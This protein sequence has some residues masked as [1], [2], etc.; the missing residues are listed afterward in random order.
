MRSFAFGLGLAATAAIGLAA[1]A[2]A[3]DVTIKMWTLDN[4]GYEEFIQ[5]AAAAFAQTHPG[6]T[7]EHQVFPGDPYK[8]GLQV[9]LVGSDGP[10][11]F[12]N[13]S[14]DDA[15]RLVKDGLAL[16][17]TDYGNAEGGF[18]TF[19]GEGWLD[20]FRYDGKLYGVPAD[21]VSKYFFYNKGYFAEHDLSVPTTFTE[22][23]GLCKAVRAID[24]DTIPM[25]MGN[26]TRW[27]AIHWMTSLNQRMLGVEGTAADY[28]LS[29]DDAE[30]FTDPGYAGAFHKLLDLQDAGCFEEA[31]NATD[32]AVADTMFTTGAS[33][34]EYC[35]SWCTSAQ[36]EA[37]FTDYGL[38]RFPAIE[39]GKGDAG[40]N[41]L[42]PEGFQVNAKSAHPKEAVEWLSFLVSG[43][44]A[45]KFAEYTGMLP[46]N[47]EKIDEVPNATEQF[48]WIAEDIA[49]F[50]GTA[51]VLDVLLDGAVAEAYLNAT[52]E[53]LNRTKTPDEAVA[54]IRAVAL[55]VK[56][57][58]D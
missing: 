11:V 43:D 48:K 41:F 4:N 38:F 2:F 5:Q 29:R 50:T 34:V 15:K 53:V 56:H 27:K 28:D 26:K 40:E 21:A 35:G 14:G 37:G 30:L 47:P 13:W 54:D 22:L 12:F 17:I 10:D 39:D 52:V 51:N 20:A 9:A 3:E 44:Q 32:Y 36:D 57:K 19:L 23:A 31:P 58:A 7:I 55:E 18:A 42:V 49:G 16:D 8:T 33:P 25:P 45:A 24:A 46:S 6:V 1:P